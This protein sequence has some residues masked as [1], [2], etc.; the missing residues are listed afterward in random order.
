M[1]EGKFSNC[2]V[3]EVL[4]TIV[5]GNGTGRLSIEGTSV[6][7]G[8]VHT[9]LYVEDARIVHVE[10]SPTTTYHILVDLFSLREGSFSF[11]SGE[12]PAV[13][14]QS[15]LVSDVVLQ[16]TAALDEWNSMRHQIGSADAV[17]ALRSDDVTSSLSLTDEQW[18]VMARLDGKASIRDIANATDRGIVCV[19]KVVLGFTEKGIAIEAQV[20]DV[21]E[22]TDPGQ[23]HKRGLFSFLAR[24]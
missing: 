17:F 12:T 21:P 14:D 13:R 8:R 1:L 20:P 23:P 15:V 19:A 11:A 7:G 16:V 6:F 5:Q 24:K 2:Q 22:D 10:T 18:N 3:D 9:T 4:Q